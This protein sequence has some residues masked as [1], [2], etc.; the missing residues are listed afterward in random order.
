MDPLLGGI[1]GAVLGGLLLGWGGAF[2]GA[3][4]GYLLLRVLRLEQKLREQSD[5]LSAMHVL[6]E[7]GHYGERIRELQQRLRRLE[8]H[9]APAAG[10]SEAV[11]EAGSVPEPQPSVRGDLP[12]ITMAEEMPCTAAAATENT[13]LIDEVPQCAADEFHPADKDHRPAWL[14]RILS[15]NP[16]AKV[17]AILLF[18]GIASGFKLAVEHGWFPLPL[19]VLLTTSVAVTMIVF[20]WQQRSE[21]PRFSDAMQGGGFAVLYLIVFFMLSR[22]GWLSPQPAFAI[23]VLLAL[24][25][26]IFALWQGTQVLAIFGSAGGFLAPVLASTGQGS[27][28]LLFSFYLLLGM[29]LIAASL[30]RGWRALPLSGMVFTFAVG[31]NWAWKNYVPANYLSTQIF[32]LAFFLL[33]GLWP[34]GIVRRFTLTTLDA[35]LTFGVPL[36]T[37]ALQYSLVD[38]WRYGFAISAAAM[39]V[40][41]LLLWTSIRGR[42]DWLPAALLGLGIAMLTASIPFAFDVVPSAALWAVEG[43]AG[44]MIAMRYRSRIG[45]LAGVALQMVAGLYMLSE[46]VYMTSLR[47]VMNT[48]CL[49]AVLIAVTGVVSAGVLARG[50]E[51]VMARQSLLA[52]GLLA[53]SLLWWFGAGWRE[54][55]QFVS[56]N[57]LRV[58]AMLWHWAGTVVVLS[59]A[60]VRFAWRDLRDSAGFLMVLLLPALFFTWQV[61]G[62]VFI[63]H[64]GLAWGIAFAAA[65]WIR[66]RQD[67]EVAESP[68]TH[69]LLFGMTVLALTV[70]AVWRAQDLLT[71]SRFGHY[72]FMLPVLS[73]ALWFCWRWPRWPVA[74]WPEIY[75]RGI[76]P[77]LVL[78][79]L[80]VGGWL[81]VVSDGAVAGLTYLPLLSVFDLLQL[82]AL[83]TI[84]REKR[85]QALRFERH[86][87]W[88]AGFVWLSMM[89]ARIA[90]AW[91]GARFGVHALL[92]SPEAATALALVWTSLALLMMW[93]AQRYANRMCWFA[94]F[95]LLCVVGAKLL[96]IDLRNV[97]TVAWTISLIGVALLVLAASYIAPAPPK[98]ENLHADG[99]SPDFDDDRRD[100]N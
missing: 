37:L 92:L 27:H 79:T 80:I 20:G 95:A 71:M 8:L 44:L 15:G 76:A 97:G 78:L 57:Q 3:V 90:T 63:G 68:F 47:P 35:P 61:F 2:A 12:S 74:R 98:E 19:R 52:R 66:W 64:A 70:E 62:H 21:R 43:M 46:L 26:M 36:A 88:L 24:A 31:L 32:L 18:F 42:A 40:L 53:W 73:L 54:I 14:I 83:S 55:D 94:G 93:L 96:L 72:L 100:T 51:P 1:I 84:W 81:N 22:W 45:M 16:L 87:L 4:L 49:S 7:A 10:E 75:P 28:I 17:G 85:I 38:P 29:T 25:C 89:P 9:E 86:A 6:F 13:P 34:L 67:D 56:G 23:F 60:G 50:A 91:F 82:A 39:G 48:A 69:A 59:L 58:A 30:W 77:V 99:Q 41:Y 33:Y 65:W 11:A 5:R